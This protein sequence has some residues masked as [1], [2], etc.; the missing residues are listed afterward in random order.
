[1]AVRT[2]HRPVSTRQAAEIA[3]CNTRHV[4]RPL[5]IWS[6]SGTNS[7]EQL[8]SSEPS[9]DIPTTLFQTNVHYHVRKA[10]LLVPVLHTLIH[11]TP[12]HLNPLNP[13]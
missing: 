8:P 4:M 11:S 7:M 2:A 3:N 12:P 9:E 6:P 10:P 5:N 13:F 1:M